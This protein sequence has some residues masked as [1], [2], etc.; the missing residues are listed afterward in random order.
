MINKNRN[1][2]SEYIYSFYDKGIMNDYSD[3]HFLIRAMKGEIDIIQ[4]YGHILSDSFKRCQRPDFSSS[5][6]INF[7]NKLRRCSDVFS[8]ESMC[9]FV[10]NQL[11]AGKEHYREESFFEAL[12][13]INVLFYFCNFVGRIKKCEYEPKQGENGANPEA[14]F[15]Y[16]DDA[17]IDI[18]VKKANFSSSVDSARGENGAIKPNIVLDQSTKASLIQVCEDNKLQLIYPRISKLGEFIKSAADKFQG[19]SSNKHFNLLF[20]NWTYTDFPEC[21]VNEP[22]SL[23]I[24]TKSGLFYNDRALPLIRHKDGTQIINRSDL[25]KI[26]A[27]I[28]YRDTMET[29]LSGDFRFHFKERTFRYSINRINNAVTDFD[30]LSRLLGMNPCN[31]DILCEWYPF[32]YMLHTKNTRDLFQKLTAMLLK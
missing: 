10:R 25:D 1:K 23:L 8:E 9:D 19:P 13:E 15:V 5:F 11:A 4:E 2:L 14:R 24:N 6:L 30:L 16:E 17:I 28:L 3:R 26:T 29:L 27:V 21:G 18:E 31:D 20:I 7:S 12:S 32:D 22:M